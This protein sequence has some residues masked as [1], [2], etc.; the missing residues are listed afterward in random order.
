MKLFPTPEEVRI[1]DPRISPRENRAINWDLVDMFLRKIVHS[2]ALTL[3]GKKLS[4]SRDA[5][6]KRRRELK[7]PPMS[8]GRPQAAELTEYEKEV[9]GYMDL[10]VKQVDIARARGVTK[11]AVFATLKRIEAKK[12]KQAEFGC[13]ECF[14]IGI[15]PCVSCGGIGPHHHVCMRC[16]GQSTTWASRGMK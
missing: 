15:V 13:N 14:G 2:G 11:G 10:G 1:N 8:T 16:G 4:I 5:L 3:L 7:L 9:V 6:N 12:A